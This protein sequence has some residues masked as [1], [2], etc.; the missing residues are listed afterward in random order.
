MN[1]KRK[2]S[3]VLTLIRH[4]EGFEKNK[5]S[6]TF[7]TDNQ[8]KL[9]KRIFCYSNNNYIKPKAVYKLK[10]KYISFLSKEYKNSRYDKVEEVF[11]EEVFIET[12]EF[13]VKI[14]LEYLKEIR[15]CIYIPSQIDIPKDS[16]VSYYKN[17]IK[18]EVDSQRISRLKEQM[19]IAIKKKKKIK[20]GRKGLD[21]FIYELEF[22]SEHKLGRQLNLSRDEVQ[23]MMED[24]KRFKKYFGHDPSHHKSML[25]KMLTETYTKDYFNNLYSGS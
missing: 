8:Y 18:K 11:V 12:C 21:R 16:H 23:N 14:L 22:Y 25:R 10:E 4:I 9:I 6:V 15:R 5:I 20:R 2:K 3:D 24:W 17:E 19:K 1:I 7:N 13:P